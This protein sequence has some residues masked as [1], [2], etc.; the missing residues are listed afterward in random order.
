M[1]PMTENIMVFV[2]YCQWYTVVY[3]GIPT[4]TC[5]EMWAIMLPAVNIAMHHSL[6]ET[7][8]LTFLH[9]P[10]FLLPHMREQYTR[11]PPQA[12]PSCMSF[13]NK[14][15]TKLIPMPG[16]REP[17]NEVEGEG[18]FT[19]GAMVSSKGEHTSFWLLRKDVHGSIHCAFFYGNSGVGRD[20]WHTDSQEVFATLPKSNKFVW[21]HCLL[22]HQVDQ[23]NGDTFTPY[24]PPQPPAY[25]CLQYP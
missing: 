4:V 19:D 12:P 11:G 9:L 6:H 14:S 21:S 1:Y 24:L 2:V 17:G 3:C 22:L 10:H 7:I 20:W 5:D 13:P 16:N 8:P 25:H 18:P 15:P 23:Q